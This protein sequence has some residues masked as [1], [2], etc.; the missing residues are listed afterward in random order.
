MVDFGHQNSKNPPCAQSYCLIRKKL[1]LE[2]DLVSLD[3]S[4]EYLGIVGTLLLF[5]GYSDIRESTLL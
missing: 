5:Q 3:I 4:F 1:D 2:V